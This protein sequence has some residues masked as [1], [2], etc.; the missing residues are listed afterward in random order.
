MTIQNNI[1]VAFS[2]M[3]AGATYATEQRDVFPL[4]CH[5]MK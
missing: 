1:K 4:L 5:S 2:A 3:L